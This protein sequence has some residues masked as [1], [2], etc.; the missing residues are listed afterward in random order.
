MLRWVLLSP[1]ARCAAAILCV[2][3]ALFVSSGQAQQ[4]KAPSKL[5]LPK[6]DP[7]PKRIITQG[8]ARSRSRTWCRAASISPA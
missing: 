5:P 1:L 3:A 7:P 2:T 6:A 8:L 4:P